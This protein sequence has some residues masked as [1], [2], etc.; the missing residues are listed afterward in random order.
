TWGCMAMRNNDIDELFAQKSIKR[1][2]K[3]YIAG[4]NIT[5]KDITKKIRGYSEKEIKRM[6]QRLIIQG[7]KLKD[8]SG[9]L[10]APTRKALGEFQIKN[11]LP[12]TCEIDRRTLDKL[13]MLKP[14]IHSSRPANQTKSQD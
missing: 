4:E 12:I 13:G 11:N 7:Y 2:V 6:K 14:P 5:K 8:L 10:D 1:G 3:V 9:K